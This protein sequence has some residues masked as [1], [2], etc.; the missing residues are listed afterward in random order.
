MGIAIP[1]TMLRQ[2]QQPL[3]WTAAVADVLQGPGIGSVWV[4]VG[5]YSITPK[6]L[7]AV[8]RAIRDGRIPVYYDPNFV[9]V[10]GAFGAY[11]DGGYDAMF[12]GFCVL[13][14]MGRKAVLVHEATHA[15][16]DMKNRAAMLHVD[17]E[18]AGY[19]AQAMYIRGMG[20][21]PP[22]RLKTT[23]TIKDAIYLGAFNVADAIFGGRGH[24][25]DQLDLLR[26][27]IRAD[28]DYA[29]SAGTTAG[30]NGI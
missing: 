3:N 30:Y 7:R 28:P 1:Q 8:G 19:T 4:Q 12:T 14:T 23:N 16:S 6:A 13:D 10:N 5:R 24:P 2:L 25:V 11:Y 21:R 17:D 27:A 29:A 20:V 18:A 22:I 9:M 26:D 15:V